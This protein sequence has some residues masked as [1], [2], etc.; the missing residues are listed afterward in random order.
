MCLFVGHNVAFRRLH[1]Q[2][3][4][5]RR[6]VLQLTK[7]VVVVVVFSEE[8]KLANTEEGQ[9]CDCF[10]LIRLYPVGV[11]VSLLKH[12]RNRCRDKTHHNERRSR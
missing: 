7:Y 10:K 8:K 2:V 6:W 4:P 3:E 5:V 11:A 12:G 1:F 9:R